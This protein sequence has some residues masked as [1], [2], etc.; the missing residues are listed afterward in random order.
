MGGRAKR[1]SPF[2]C[3]KKARGKILPRAR[4]SP[5]AHRNAGFFSGLDDPLLFFFPI[6]DLPTLF[7]AV[8]ESEQVDFEPALLPANGNRRR[9]A[10]LVLALL[11]ENQFGEFDEPHRRNLRRRNIL[12][13]VSDDR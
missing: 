4:L 1:G 10:L 11:V 3:I 12:P 13:G 5:S 2:S 8:P 7:P 6:V 9:K